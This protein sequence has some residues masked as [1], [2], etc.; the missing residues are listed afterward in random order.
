MAAA[1]YNIN[2]T[3]DELAKS[4][5][6]F[7]KE[8]LMMPAF[9]LARGTAYMTPRPG[10]TYKETV[11]ELAGNFEIGPYDPKRVDA[12]GLEI[13]G[14]TLETFLGSVIKEFDPNSAAKTIWASLINKGEGLA[15][16]DIAQQ[17]LVYLMKKLG[18]N[19]YN[20]LWNAKRNDAG[21]TTKE[22]FNGF[23]T[24]AETEIAAGGISKDNGNLADIPAAITKENAYD[25][26]NDLY[27]AAND[28]LQESDSVMFLPVNTFQDY[29]ADYK[30]VT[31][32]IPY[33]TQYEQVFLE[34][35][36]GRCRLVPMANKKGSKFIT[37][38]TKENMLYGYGNGADAETVLVERFH[39]LLLTFTAVMF[40]GVQYE[41]INAERL[42]IGK[43]LDAPNP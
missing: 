1:N 19:L 21:T 6:K 13:T 27:R 33:N 18:D 42:L 28:H 26:L 14:R 4:A 29:L 38:T 10:V 22:L 17:V 3:P 25:S 40:F 20:A 43:V 34:A 31:G 32:G 30:A 37:L 39:P 16:V 15:G 2:V 5:Q 24:I 11:G 23:D 36:C 8:L 12:E 35:S 7:R 9:S 41:S